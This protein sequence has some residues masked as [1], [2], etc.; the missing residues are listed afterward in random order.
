MI[1]FLIRHLCRHWRLNLAVLLCLALAS[2]FLAG[3]AAYTMGIET[4]ELRQ[5]LV[6]AH[7]TERTLLVTGPRTAFNPAFYDLF[8]ERLGKLLAQRLVI[9]HAVSPADPLPA[10]EMADRQAI[11]LLDLYAF[12]RL[13][14]RVRL[15]EGRLPVQ[16]RLREAEDIWRPPPIEVVIG[17]AAARQS[18]YG[19]G[20]QLSGSGT[21]H[22]LDI[23]G[24][25]EPLD[26]GAD[27]WSQDL[28]AFTVMSDRHDLVLP[29]ILAEASMRSNYPKQPIFPH[30][31]AWRIVLDR[32]RI[33]AD[34]ADALRA[35]LLNLQTQSTTREAE[36]STDL[37][38]IL[39]ETLARLSRVRASF[40]LLTAQTLLFVLYT[41]TVFT[42]FVMERARV[43]LAVLS[44]RGASAWQI[45]RI[46]AVQNLILALAAGLLLGPALA[47]AAIY[48]WR[49]GAG[50]LMP[51]TLPGRAWLFSGIVAGFGWLALVL[52]VFLSARRSARHQETLRAHPLQESP[53]QKRYLDL[54][55]LAFAGLLYWQLN[56]SGS[57]LMRQL[58]DTQMADPLLL[59]GPTLLL[60]AAAAV[61]L[62]IVPFLLRLVAWPCQR[63]RGWALSLGLL[64]LARAPQRAGRMVLLITLTAGLLLFGRTYGDSLGHNRDALAQG[65]ARAMELNTLA[66]LLFSLVA[67]FLANLL[68][69]RERQPEFAVLG[70]LGISLRQAAALLVLE[71]L[72]VV[73][74]GLLTGNLA[75]WGLARIMI[76]YLSQSL[77]VESIVTDWTDVLRLHALLL[78]VYGLALGLVW[79]IQ[80]RSQAL[81]AQSVGD[82]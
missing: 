15:V 41:L 29:L 52:P 44:A 19:P 27:I 53:I 40:F 30:T 33:S 1:E 35:D 46:F 65:V 22:R 66:I 54:Y 23:V 9:R 76:P 60:V 62:R 48:L 57:F 24:I 5:T 43:E 31:V 47:Q 71:G 12:D 49:R 38:R 59:L 18:G 26:P 32:E 63:L 14:E 39:A 72:I 28:S 51:G 34:G 45:A 81:W 25:V 56:Q 11:A 2:A 61:F 74:S 4:G 58:G 67:F 50:E 36:I 68:A 6:E 16:V 8:Q 42:S 13:A 80:L 10:E 20:D 7:P 70:S 75:G 73:V 3:F 55:L 77:A 78:A 21:Y 79:L 17:Q 82:E 37:A 64:H 69:A